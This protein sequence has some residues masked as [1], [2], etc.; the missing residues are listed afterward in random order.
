MLLRNS[1]LAAES[2]EQV[3]VNRVG[4]LVGKSSRWRMQPW[5]RD[6][7]VVLPPSSLTT[8]LS[9]GVTWSMAESSWSS[10]R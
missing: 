7:R 8:N 3:I 4:K 6:Q 5:T 9:L 2:V 1:R 10:W